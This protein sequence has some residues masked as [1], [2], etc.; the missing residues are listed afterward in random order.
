MTQL[1]PMLAGTVTAEELVSLSYPLFVQEK[2]D[3]IRCLI[4]QD[5]RV[6]TRSLKPLPNLYIQKTLGQLASRDYV[7]DGELMLAK[8]N[9]SF[10][11]IVS[12]TMT[13]SGEPD[14]VFY[15]F[16]IVI[17]RAYSVR[18]AVLARVVSE[19]TVNAPIVCVPVHIANTP[20]DV[21]RLQSE[22]LANGQEGAMVRH[23]DGLYKFGR[24]TLKS[25]G[26]LKFKNFSDS[27]AKIIGYEQRFHNANEAK[28]NELGRTERSSHK[29]NMIPV[30][31]LGAIVVQDVFSGVQFSIG[32]GFTDA[33]RTDLW[34]DPESLLGKI[35]KYRY[36][37]EGIDP[38]TGC[39]RF[40]VFIGFRHEY[41]M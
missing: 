5:G 31:Q 1:K 17:D 28:T 6:V 39:P 19:T 29:E 16:D 7:L 33:V 3:G 35:V 11:E 8:P 14:F 13:E 26:L 32:T 4:L 25:Q 36:Q 22:F 21:I 12:A 2:L 9:A 37:S 27:D 15:A 23:P 18:Q 24:S 10:Q 20:D 38:K 30:D 40:P 34:K 41:D